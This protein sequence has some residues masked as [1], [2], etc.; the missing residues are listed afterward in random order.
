MAGELSIRP[1]RSEDRLSMER[2]CAQTFDWGD[3]VP[4]VWDDWLADEQGLAIVGEVGRRVV[5]LSKI[6]FQTTEEVWLEGMRVE[7]EYRR[8]GIAGRFLDYSLAHCRERGARVVRLGT[9]SRNTA[10]H[11]MV[12]RAGME[13]VCSCVLWSADPA[14]D[15]PQPTV[16]SPDYCAEV[17]AF[18]LDSP[19]LAH[20]HGLYSLDWVWQE[21]TAEQLARFVN[22]GQMIAQLADEGNLV[23][24]APVFFEPEDGVIWIGFADGQPEAIADL[25]LTIRV[26]AAQI[27]AQQVRIML[28]DLGWLRDAFGA[29]GYG[30]GD[31]EGELWVFERRLAGNGK[32]NRGG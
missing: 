18:L 12:G 15:G 24:L 31:W 1:A 3:Y 29:A 2:I 30:F 22:I 5:A 28:P 27:G 6:T 4:E 19:V 9:S 14:P 25:A 20:T 7:P 23:A 13:R 26:H 10:V 16:L 21:L 17:E 32:G 11:I 8:Q